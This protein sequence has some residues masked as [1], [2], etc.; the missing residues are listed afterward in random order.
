MTSSEKNLRK[1]YLNKKIN[2]T[3][4]LQNLWHSP[5]RALVNSA[6]DES[7]CTDLK[8]FEFLFTHII[9]TPPFPS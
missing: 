4:S 6:K 1:K 9:L 3:S 2:P 8:I 5:N 7:N